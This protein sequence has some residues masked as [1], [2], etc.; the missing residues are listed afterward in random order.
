MITAVRLNGQNKY[1]NAMAIDYKRIYLKYF[2]YGD[3]SYVPCELCGS[4]AE[5]IHHI[6]YR[7]RGGGN[8]IGNLMALCNYHHDLAHSEILTEDDLQDTH[9]KFMQY[10]V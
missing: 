8:E 3:Q 4:Y 6:N 9:N 10:H 7:S 1:R 2:G 5:S